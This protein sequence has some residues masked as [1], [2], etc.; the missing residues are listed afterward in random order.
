MDSL[1][2]LGAKALASRLKRVSDGLMSEVDT[3]YRELNLAFDPPC[4]PLF[5]LVLQ[6][7]TKDISISDAAQALG[8]SHAAV[9]Q[10]AAKLVKRGYIELQT[11]EGDK[12]SKTIHVTDAGKD[13]ATHLAPFWQA[14]D[15][16]IGPLLRE[17][18]PFMHQIAKLED[19][20]QSGQFRADI[21]HRYRPIQIFNWRPEWSHY[22]YQLNRDWVEQFFEMEPIDEAVLSD[23]EHYILHDGGQVFFA[24]YKGEILGTGALM[25]TG[26]NEFEFTKMAISAEHRGLG[27]GKML[28]KHALDYAYRSLDAKEVWLLTSSKLEAANTLYAQ[29][30]FVP[31]EL[32]EKDRAKY[33]R[34]DRKWRYRFDI[35][36]EP[37]LAA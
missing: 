7:E 22:F 2:K 10:K 26:E 3:V 23:P 20:I 29:V 6:N 14:I 28:I 21:I 4:Y 9:S 35:K 1:Y 36:G 15:F 5:A 31:E 19:Y 32:T 25:R 13:I 37:K 34:A 11:V 24:Q 12:R 18:N 33:K 17:Q 27:M 8:I 16:A 30:G